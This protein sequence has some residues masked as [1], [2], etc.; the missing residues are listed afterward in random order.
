M[1][2]VK[3]STSIFLTVSE[4]PSAR[5]GEDACTVHRP[6]CIWLLSSYMLKAC[7]KVQKRSVRSHYMLST[8]LN[9]G[10]SAVGGCVYVNDQSHGAVGCS[11]L[12]N[13]ALLDI[14]ETSPQLALT[15]V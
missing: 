6:G 7:S 1:L 3:D 11:K 15:C 10:W 4:I 14:A 12:Q 2:E 13:P 5:R 9:G 8:E